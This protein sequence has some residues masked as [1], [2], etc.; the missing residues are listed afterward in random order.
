MKNIALI[1][2]A[3]TFT[4]ACDVQ[5][6]ISKKELEKFNSSP[7]PAIS[8]P[9]PEPIDAADIL[10]VDAAASGPTININKP[11]EGKR[12]KCDKYN[13]VAINGDGKEVNI[14]GACRQIMINGD[15][16]IVKATAVTEV[17]V[18]GYQNKVEFYK[19][20]NGKHPVIADSG[21]STTVIKSPAPAAGTKSAK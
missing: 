10:T 6:G 2:I 21:G 9:T 15:N 16:N 19:Y 18:N 3:L 12:V 14:E 8:V 13:R 17:V 7:T 20:A 11:E 1:I 4:V 5:S